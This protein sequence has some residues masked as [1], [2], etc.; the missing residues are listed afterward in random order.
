[1]YAIAIRKVLETPRNRG[2]RSNF[3]SSSF[4]FILASSQINTTETTDLF[5]K[6]YST[7]AI[8]IL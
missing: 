5:N 7:I 8:L 6:P 2:I 3:I 4:L 1:M